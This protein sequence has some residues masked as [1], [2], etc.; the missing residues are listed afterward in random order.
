MS[1]YTIIF[2]F[3]A[4]LSVSSALFALFSNNMVHAVMALLGVFLGVSGLFVFAG[5]D[6]LALAQLVIYVGGVLVLMLFGIMFTQRGSG[7]TAPEGRRQ[8]WNAL[9]LSSLMLAL[10][11]WLF[12]SLPIPYHQLK[13]SSES[14][15]RPLGQSLLSEFLLPFELA[16]LLLLIA[17]IGAV[18]IAGRKNG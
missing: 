6:F 10:L 8:V 3:F 5:A 18:H 17:L 4:L 14:S 1:I 9:F 13:L 15:I 12:L 11:A 16:G 2:Y 7:A